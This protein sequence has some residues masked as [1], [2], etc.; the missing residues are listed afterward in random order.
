MLQPPYILPNASKLRYINAFLY[1]RMDPESSND[2][3]NPETEGKYE[4]NLKKFHNCNY[5]NR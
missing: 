1:F 4:I 5:Q 2:S 3:L